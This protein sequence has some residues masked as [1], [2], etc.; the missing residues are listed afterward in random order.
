MKFN[1]EKKI[2]N[3]IEVSNRNTKINICENKLF[4]SIK[5]NMKFLVSARHCCMPHRLKKLQ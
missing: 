4:Y 5:T 1:P 2:S 3:I